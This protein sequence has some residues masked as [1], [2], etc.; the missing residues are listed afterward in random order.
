MQIFFIKEIQTSS[1]L[2]NQVKNGIISRIQQAV[3][4]T[5]QT[6]TLILPIV[7]KGIKIP[8][9]ADIGNYKGLS[10]E[11]NVPSYGNL[12]TFEWSSFFPTKPYDFIK[13][14][15]SSNGYEYVTFL[16]ERQ[17]NELP[18]RLVIVEERQMPFRMLFDN[19]VLVKNFEYSVDNVGDI[20]YFLRLEEFNTG[21]ITA[22][23]GRNEVASAFVSGMVNTITNSALK[24]SGLI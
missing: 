1:D 10:E 3:N 20:Q 24:H 21:M 23:I 5:G 19:F 6:Q 17:E 15:S 7:P 12:A 9:S 4:V 2:L 8:V 18:F 13:T 16:T 22:T 14:G 11:Y